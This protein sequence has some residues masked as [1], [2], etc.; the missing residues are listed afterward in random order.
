MVRKELDKKLGV[1]GRNITAQKIQTL[2]LAR[3]FQD[4]QK[5]FQD[6]QKQFEIRK[7]NI[8]DAHAKYQDAQAKHQDVHKQFEYA[9]TKHQYAHAKLVAEM[10]LN[11]ELIR[12]KNITGAG[13]REQRKVKRPELREKVKRAR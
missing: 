10:G 11:K 5:Q 12:L 2:F 1:A 3:Q 8:Q 6:V 4:V 9:Q 7:Q 13:A